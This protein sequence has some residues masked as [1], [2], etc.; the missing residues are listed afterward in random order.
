MERRDKL[1][2]KNKGRLRKREMINQAYHTA[3][4]SGLLPNMYWW[5]EGG[6]DIFVILW[7]LGLQVSSLQILKF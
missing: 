2:F 5:E 3:F 1:G 7:F 4:S 6:R